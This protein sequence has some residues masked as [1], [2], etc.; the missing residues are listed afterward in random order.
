MLGVLILLAILI[1]VFFCGT[2][3]EHQG[4]GSVGMILALIFGMLLFYNTV[5]T[6]VSHK[7]LMEKNLG[8]YQIVSNKAVFVL[9]EF[10][11]EE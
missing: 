6:S 7:E 8:Q 4:I 10:K 1:A 9:R 3:Q 5:N 2:L 11:V